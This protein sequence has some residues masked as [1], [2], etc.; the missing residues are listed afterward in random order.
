MQRETVTRER[1][2]GLPQAA[3]IRSRFLIQTLNEDKLPG[4][5]GS[6]LNGIQVLRVLP[7]QFPQGRIRLL[8]QA[9]AIELSV[10]PKGLLGVQGQ[11]FQVRGKS[12]LDI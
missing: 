9:G 4:R 3:L 10:L 5:G 12:A 11:Q 8:L 2:L 1:L 7:Q 6:G